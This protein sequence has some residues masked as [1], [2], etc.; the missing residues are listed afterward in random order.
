MDLSYFYSL[1]FNFLC[2]MRR[3]AK[4]FFFRR[5]FKSFTF[6]ENVT[7]KSWEVIYL[8]SERDD[9]VQFR[10]KVFTI[11]ANP[12]WQKLD[13]PLDEFTS[14]AASDVPVYNN[15]HMT[16]KQPNEDVVILL[17]TPSLF[18]SEWF[19]VRC[20]SKW[21]LSYHTI[22]WRRRYISFLPL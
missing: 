7:W 15:I 8:F 18:G 5:I 1:F 6:E 9:V 22:S 16:T 12:P 17:E 3:E 19:A 11:L 4:F 13:F 21:L 10:R 2:Y 14:S 20:F